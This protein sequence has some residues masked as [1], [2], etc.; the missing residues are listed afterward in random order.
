MADD[1]AVV[2]HSVPNKREIPQP[3]EFLSRDGLDVQ[4]SLEELVDERW[5]DA[6][7]W[8]LIE[9]LERCRRLLG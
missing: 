5:V 1:C 2:G 9:A 8:I 4:R 3:R 6:A 7:N